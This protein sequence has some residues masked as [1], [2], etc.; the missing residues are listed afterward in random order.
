MNVSKNSELLMKKMREKYDIEEI[1]K[2]FY[3]KWSF[4]DLLILCN[5]F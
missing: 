3:N 5:L 1:L 2:I 4:V